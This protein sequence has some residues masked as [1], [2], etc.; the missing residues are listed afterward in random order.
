VI[1]D[2]HDQQARL[3]S[4]QGGGDQTLAGLPLT[5]E[6]SSGNQVVNGGTDMTESAARTRAQVVI[7]GGTYVPSAYD[8]P[9]EGPSLSR[10]HLEE[11]FSG[12]I[13]GVGS[14]ELLQVTRSDGQASFAGKSGSPA[15]SAGGRALLVPGRR[16][17]TT[18]RSWSGSPRNPRRSTCARS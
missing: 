10:I 15:G 8:E 9:A 4:R 17:A 7:T 11:D 16:Q 2:R 12:D 18:A 6:A 1:S 13:T 5:G 3:A 14:A